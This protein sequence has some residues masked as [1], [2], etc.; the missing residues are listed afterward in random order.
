[1]IGMRGWEREVGEIDRRGG[2]EK[3]GRLLEKGEK[4][5]KQRRGEV[6]NPPDFL[7]VLTCI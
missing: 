1:M 5:K 7:Q 2:D 6:M 4:G 3:R